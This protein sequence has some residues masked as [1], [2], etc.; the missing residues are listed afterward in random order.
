[1]K[2]HLGMAFALALIGAGCAPSENEPMIDAGTMPTDAARVEPAKGDLAIRA[3]RLINPRD[4]KIIDN[5]I[6]VIDAGR[7]SYVGTDPAMIPANATVLDWSGFTA[8]PG[9]ID[10]H[11]HVG[12]QADMVSA[13]Q[14][15][16]DR[17]NELGYDELLALSRTAA[18]AALRRG[19]TTMIDKGARMGVDLALRDEIAAGTTRGPRLFVAGS[20]ISFWSS[21]SIPWIEMEIQ[22]Q[23]SQG[24][25]LVKVW[26]DACSD[27]VLECTGLF[28]QAHLTAAVE[29]AH[30][31]GKPIA[32]HAYHADAAALAIE[33]GPDAL[34][35][36]EGLDAGMLQEMKDRGTVY[37]PTIDHNRYYKDNA[38][39]FKHEATIP[40]FDAFIAKNVATAKAAITAGVHVAMGSDAVFTGFGENTRELSW[41]VQAGMTPMAAL[42]AATVEGARSLGKEAE[43]GRIEPHSIADVIAVEGDPL[44][45]IDVAVNNVRAV[46]K[47]GKRIEL[48]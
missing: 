21:S 4:G 48:N 30:A 28:T 13:M 35:H 10:A 34:E 17:L 27:K 39:W 2:T 31:H 18:L 42:A 46:V 37:V 44:K 7:F 38:A 14:T 43:L 9:F 40:E 12:F 23:V 32:I 15:P 41:L 45:S 29:A 25:D 8:L 5:A 6:L 22:R 19:V 1:M 24:I 36:A 20:G 47:D 16:W 33:A 26:A 11:T 3:G